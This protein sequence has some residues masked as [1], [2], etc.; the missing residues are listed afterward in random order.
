VYSLASYPLSSLTQEP[1]AHT[2]DIDDPPKQTDL[3]ADGVIGFGST[4]QNDADMVR[5]LFYPAEGLP[6]KVSDFLNM[7]NDFNVTLFVN[8]KSH[9]WVFLLVAFT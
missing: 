5:A 7:V 3:L 4:D 8:A 1:T 2:S 9:N 6:P